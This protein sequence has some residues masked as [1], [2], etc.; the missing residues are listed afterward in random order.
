MTKAQIKTVSHSGASLVAQM[1]KTLPAIPKTRIL[2]L[3]Q[4]DPLE[5]GMAAH[6]SVFGANVCVCVCAIISGV[7]NCLQPYG[8]YLAR[9]LCPRDSTRQEYW[10]RLPCPPPGDPDLRMEPGLLALK[11]RFFTA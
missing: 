11:G 8:L 7:F 5:K 4:E 1:V 2:S 6:S 10:S 9:L 3:G